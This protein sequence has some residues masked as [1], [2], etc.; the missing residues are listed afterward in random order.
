MNIKNTFYLILLTIFIA[1]CSGEP[2]WES[3]SIDGRIT[4][5]DSIDNSGD[6]SGIEVVIVYQKSIDSEIDTLFN[7]VT[8]KSGIVKGKLDFPEKGVYPVFFRRN[9]N[10]IGA[11]QFIL[12]KNDTI[13]FSGELPGL[14]Q[15]FDIDS[16]EHRAMKTFNRINRGF[17]RVSTYISAGAIEDSLLYG[18]VFKWSELYWEVAQKNPNTV[19]SNLAVSESV[20]LLNMLDKS[21]MMTR[22]DQSLDQDGRIFVAANYGFSHVSKSEGIE[23][24]VS[25]LDSLMTLTNDEEIVLSLSKLKIEAYYDSS[26][27]DEAKNSLSEFESDYKDNKN[28]MEWAKTIGYDLVYLAPGFRVPNFNFITQEGDSVNAASLVGKPYI[29]EITPIA[30]RIYQNQYDRTV[31]IHQIYQNYGL[32]IFTIPLD[33]SEVTVNAFFEERVKHWPVASFNSFDIQKLIEN[34]NV[35]DVPTRILVDQN[36]NIVRKYVTTEFTDVIQGLNTI[37]NQTKRES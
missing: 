34:F 24:G 30:S 33:Q 9:G 22:I 29:L 23:K 27:I 7:K 28:A 15:T 36:G 32:D 11:T 5:A 26:R 4:V 10:Q 18:E 16:R 13:S 6:Y 12:A 31:V 19:A 8:N 25:Y 14:D 3:V 20:K 17:N 1:N 37:I 21:L 2:K 35:T